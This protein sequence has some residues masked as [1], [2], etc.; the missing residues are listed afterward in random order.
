M[1]TKR[2]EFTPEEMKLLFDGGE[3]I[4]Q[5]MKRYSRGYKT[6][7]R[8]LKLAGVVDTAESGINSRIRIKFTKE[9]VEEILHMYKEGKSLNNIGKYYGCNNKPIMRELKKAGVY[10]ERITAPPLNPKQAREVI[11]LYKK[12]ASVCGLARKYNSTPPTIKRLLKNANV[13]IRAYYIA[14]DDTRPGEKTCKHCKLSKPLSE[15]TPTKTGRLGVLALC[16]KCN[17]KRISGFYDRNP[18]SR[19]LTAARKRAKEKGIPINITENDII[20]PDI[21]PILGIPLERAVGMG[22]GLRGQNSPSLDR[23]IP[24]LGYVKGNVWVISIRANILKRDAT[25]AELQLL[26]QKLAAKIKQIS[27][28]KKK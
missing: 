25:L 17:A 15:F 24:E 7:V 10:N 13:P 6:I 12:G 1:S 5:L 22:S 27:K 18:S 20:I 23:I 19:M 9:Q 28:H 21:C 4:S 26:V 14:I 2:K 8:V 3:T 16:K 11:S